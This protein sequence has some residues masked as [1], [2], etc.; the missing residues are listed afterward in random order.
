MINSGDLIK[1]EFYYCTDYG[2]SKNNNFILLFKEDWDC[3]YVSDTMNNVHSKK[4]ENE[5]GFSG[6]NLREATLEEQHWLEV[7]ILSNKYIEK[8]EA[9]KTYVKPIEPVIQDDP[10]LSNILIKL[11]TQ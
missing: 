7:C 1:G 8:D 4:F 10:E 6:E 9:M 3:T 11:L 2:G 5:G